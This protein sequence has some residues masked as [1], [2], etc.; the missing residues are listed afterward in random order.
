MNNML[1]FKFPSNDTRARA[2][3]D[4]TEKKGLAP[5]ND[6]NRRAPEDVITPTHQVSYEPHVII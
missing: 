2:E 6:R 4:V 5:G 1:A 3:V